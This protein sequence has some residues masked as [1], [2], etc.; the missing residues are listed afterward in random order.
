MAARETNKRALAP[1]AAGQVAR[2]GGGGLG[3]LSVVL[4]AGAGA[5]PGAVRGAEAAAGGGGMLA[6]GEGHSA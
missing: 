5:A 1:G 2:R 6:P 3:A 4:K